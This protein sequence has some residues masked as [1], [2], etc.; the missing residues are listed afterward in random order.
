MCFLSPPLPFPGEPGR[1]LFFSF[2]SAARERI[3][4]Q[5][6]GEQ[7]KDS[8][9]ALPLRLPLLRL[10]S[11]LS[12]DDLFGEEGFSQ[13][14]TFPGPGRF[15]SFSFL[16]AAREKNF[17][18]PLLGRERQLSSRSLPFVRMLPFNAQGAEAAGGMW[19]GRSTGAWFERRRR[20]FT[21]G[22]WD[23]GYSC[24]RF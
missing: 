16:S 5:G 22:L 23:V 18:F 2:L 12:A 3:F 6:G 8:C 11:F 14:E 4:S 1:P 17:F 7:A 21:F 19:L 20:R 10:C 13:G 9:Q 15:L 24:W